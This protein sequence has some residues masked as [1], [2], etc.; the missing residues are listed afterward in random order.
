MN[1]LNLHPV[2]VTIIGS[3][4]SIIGVVLFLMIMGGI[5]T[6]FIHVLYI[7]SKIKKEGQYLLK[8]FYFSSM[9][10]EKSIYD[11]IITVYGV[12]KKMDVRL[13]DE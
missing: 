5:L 4:I 2:E 6:F 10:I 7:R 1:S 11:Q 3:S 8:L 12:Y 9:V 13:K